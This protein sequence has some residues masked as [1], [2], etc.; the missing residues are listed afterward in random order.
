MHMESKI[1]SSLFYMGLISAIMA[2][3]LTSFT[4]H[5]S[6]KEQVEDNLQSQAQIIAAS[7]QLMEN[8]S[9]QLSQLETDGARMTLIDPS[10]E[11]L[12]DSGAQSVSLGNHANR[13]EVKQALEMGSGYSSRTSDTLTKDYHYYAIRLKDGNILRLSV[14]TGSM[15]NTVWDASPVLLGILLVLLIL[16]VLF[17]II[18]TR[19]LVAPIKQLSEQI[20]SPQ[21]TNDEEPAVYAELVPFVQEIQLQRAQIQR[22]LAELTNEKD[23]LEAI[24]RQMTEGMILL[25]QEM[26][27]ILVNQSALQYLQ[28]E[29]LTDATHLLFLSNNQDLNECIQTAV[30]GSSESKIIPMRGKQIQILTNPVKSGDTQIGVICLMLDVT[31]REQIEHLRREF[32]ANVSHELKTPLT[33]ISGY[34]EMIA[35]GIA[36]QEDIAQFAGVIQKEAAR[37]L[38]LI[39]DIIK[40]SELDESSLHTETEP[41]DL[42]AVAEECFKTLGSA[43]EQKQLSFFLE[44][45]PSI[46]TGSWKLIWELVYNLCDNAIRYTP[47]GG[48]V[49]V[50]AEDC[51]IT[52]SDTGIGIPKEHQSRVFER[53]YRVDKSRSKETGGT[54][55]GL[56]IVKHVAEQHG[57]VISLKSE[58][59]KGTEIQVSFP[60]R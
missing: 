18:L 9:E 33:S 16:A 53:F 57:A 23:K 36:K 54:G 51:R 39:S 40:L 46:V 5:E 28:A 11:V 29:S 37:L 30:R 15:Y 27:V 55:L 10:G 14:E 52:V 42:Y 32:T 2:I 4:L 43:A 6:L 47:A 44:G 48:T 26:R 1:T 35:A 41:V 19:K 49:K 22:Q 25:D 34:A 20:D 7:Y 13:P 59:Q 38:S 17:S 12:Y 21:L 60:E 24:I 45:K 58:V 3:I 31:E 56:S 50:T 8:P